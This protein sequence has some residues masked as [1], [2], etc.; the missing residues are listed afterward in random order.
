[1]PKSLKT[2]KKVGYPFF[3]NSIISKLGFVTFMIVQYT[4]TSDTLA[5]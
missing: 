5:T 4:S 1:M 2:P 3:G